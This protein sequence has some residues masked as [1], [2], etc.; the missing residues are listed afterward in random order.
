MGKLCIAVSAAFELISFGFGVAGIVFDFINWKETV[1]NKKRLEAN[2]TNTFTDVTENTNSLL[3]GGS[4]CKDLLDMYEKLL[5]RTGIVKV[6]F[7]AIAEV[8][9]ATSLI[10]KKG[11]NNTVL[12]TLILLFK[13]V[14]AVIECVIVY[15]LYLVAKYCLEKEGKNVFPTLL[16]DLETDMFAGWFGFVGIIISKTLWANG[17]KMI[18]GVKPLISC[19]RNEGSKDGV[20][21]FLVGLLMIA[22]CVFLIVINSLIVAMYWKNK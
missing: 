11:E 7:S 14:V 21:F 6:V 13:L 3:N 16:P 8:L 15:T 10:M 12:D 4:R 17:S 9:C 1:E 2:D 18:E 5:L 20:W 19:C 22:A